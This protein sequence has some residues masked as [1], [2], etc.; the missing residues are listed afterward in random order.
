[1]KA[2]PVEKPA[3]YAPGEHPHS[4]ANLLPYQYKPGENGHKGYNLKER[5]YHSLDHP[6]EAPPEDATSGEQ[7]VYETI[8]GAIGLVPVA[9]KEVWDRV[10]GNV[11]VAQP[12]ASQDNRVVNI[13]VTSDKAKELMEKVADRL[14][15][16]EST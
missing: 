11:P 3:K 16:T 6:L 14:K 1:M 8:K 9:F 2:S 5:L 12:S 13:Y 15:L 4:R 7:L 10:E